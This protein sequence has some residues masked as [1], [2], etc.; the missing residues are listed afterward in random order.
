MLQA[1]ETAVESSWET[2]KGAEGNEMG[3][4]CLVRTGAGERQGSDQFL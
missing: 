4:E 3:E 1:L 2:S